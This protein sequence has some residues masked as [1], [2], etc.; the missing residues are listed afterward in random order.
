MIGQS[1][2]S[3]VNASILRVGYSKLRMNLKGPAKVGLPILAELG[4]QTTVKVFS[5]DTLDSPP[6]AEALTKNLYSFFLSFNSSLSMNF[7]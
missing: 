4:P 3:V 2:I 7:N 6:S 5:L 1:A